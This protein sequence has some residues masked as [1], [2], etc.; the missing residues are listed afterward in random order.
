MMTSVD[1]LFSS[2]LHSTTSVRGPSLDVKILRLKSQIMTSKAGPRTE[3]IKYL[4]L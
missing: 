3:R 4:D 2:V 1:N